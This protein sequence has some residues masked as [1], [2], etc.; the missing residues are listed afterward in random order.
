[1]HK[2]L[3]FIST[4]IGLKL[5]CITDAISE[6]HVNEGNIISPSSP[7]KIFKASSVN[8]FA[9][10]PELTKTLYLTP[11]HFD[12]FSSNSLTFV[13]CVKIMR[14]L[15]FKNRITELISSDKILFCINGW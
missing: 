12:H 6:I 8:K 7:Y 2:V 14:L 11:S 15:L 10:D 4:K 5:F 9:E 1:M 3:G 13:D